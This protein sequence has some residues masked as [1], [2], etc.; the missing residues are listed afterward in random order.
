MASAVAPSETR[1]H[2][3][4]SRT[5]TQPAASLQKKR[6]KVGQ[7]S[8]SITELFLPALVTRKMLQA[9]QKKIPKT[10][11]ARAALDVGCGWQRH[12]PNQVGFKIDVETGCSQG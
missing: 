5:E 8:L 9:G 7:S 12:A 6:K 11:R 4:V 2:W 1:E 3:L 10:P